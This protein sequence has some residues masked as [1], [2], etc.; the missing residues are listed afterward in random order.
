MRRWVTRVLTGV[1]ASAAMMV[2]AVFPACAG[3]W[4]QDGNGWRWQND[5]GSYPVNQWAWIDGNHD[6]IAEC[7]YLGADSYMLSNTTIQGMVI[8]MNGCMTEF[9]VIQT[10]TLAGKDFEKAFEMVV[11]MGDIQVIDYR[12]PTETSVNTDVDYAEIDP[13]ELAYRIVE[14][15]NVERARAGKGE[16]AVNDELMDNAM[17]R[18]EEI[19][20]LFSH[21]R[22]NGTAFYSAITVDHNSSGENIVW[23]KHNTIEA[24]AVSAVD[25]WLI[26]NGHKINMLKSNW[27]ETGV[28]V[29]VG[30]DGVNI[31]Q[32]FIQ[33]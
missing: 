17:L 19:S 30:H 24:V 29:C 14:L 13:Q 6:G 27:K 26:S 8:D 23:E 18:A 11:D 20:E 16:L 5:D 7:Y 21:T 2:V 3:E 15:V 10:T 22:P 28:G 4:R 32:V 1:V 12:D 9:G 33:K 31:V 25:S